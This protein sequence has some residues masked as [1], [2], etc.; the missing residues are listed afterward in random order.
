MAQYA[1][2]I[3]ANASHDH[4]AL[5]PE[6]R[7]AHD[8]HGEAVEKFG[9]TMLTAFAL[10]PAATATSIRGDV[11]TDGPFIDAKEVVAGF[12]VIEAPDLDAAMEI[13]RRNPATQQGGG[14]EVRPVDSGFVGVPPTAG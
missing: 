4:A 11:V 13:A 7:A 6:D 9:G 12:Y 14:V 8:R 5:S 1:I 10:Q 3:F 2:L